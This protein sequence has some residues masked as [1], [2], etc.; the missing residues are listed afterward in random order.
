MLLLVLYAEKVMAQEGTET[1]DVADQKTE[2]HDNQGRQQGGSHLQRQA[3]VT[4]QLLAVG[5]QE[6]GQEEVM[7]QIDVERTGA[8]KLKGGEP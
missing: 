1:D 6:T 4:A 5:H 2:S 8:D 3:V 7:E